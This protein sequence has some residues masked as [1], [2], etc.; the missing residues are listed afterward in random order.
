MISGSTNRGDFKLS[1]QEVYTY[2][3]AAHSNAVSLVTA[4][5]ATHDPEFLKQAAER[6]PNDPLVQSK[7]LAND[8]FPGERAKWIEALKKSSPENSFPNLMAA[9]DALKQGDTT[10][11]LAELNAA[12]S[13]G[14]NDFTRE[15]MQGLEEAYLS[16]GRTL[17]E[18][19]ALGTAEITLPHMVQ[20]NGL[21]RDLQKAAYERAGA[22]DTA[23]QLQFLKANYDAGAQFRLSPTQGILITDLVGLGM[24]NATLRAWPAGTPAPFLDAAPADSLAAN[25]AYRKDIQVGAPL[26][27]KWFPTA[28]EQ[29]VI[30]YMD[31]AKS[32]GELEAIKWLRERHPELETSGP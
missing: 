25:I 24:Q 27:E 30:N 9:R 14:F 16:A 15:S 31:R 20:F 3:Q 12:G 29:E 32:F 22:G 5:Q 10:R 23:G 7:I 28:P 11:A 18:A 6:F 13:K 21:G 8:I 4:F 17:P 26:F 2:L 1:P 19:K